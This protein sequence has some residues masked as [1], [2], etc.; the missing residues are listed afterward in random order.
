MNLTEAD[1]QILP[2]ALRKN[3]GFPIACKWYFKDW[4]PLWYQYL[5]H[6][7]MIRNTCVVAGIASGKSTGVA[8]SY[9]LD[10]LT[11]PY[12][13]A[14]NTS[15]TAKQAEIPF[16]MV[17]AW[18]DENPRLTP[19]IEDIS[20][21]PYPTIKFMNGSEWIFRTAGKDARFI[22][23]LEY[24][25][26][27][28]DECGLDF[29]GETVRVLRGRLRGVRPD[30]T[31]RMARLDTITSP[32]DAPWLRERFERGDKDNPAADLK[33][34]FSL[35]IS[36]YMNERLDPEQIALMESEYT[37]DMIDVELKGLF[38][39]Y[40]ASFFPKK[41]VQACTDQSLNDAAEEALHPEDGQVKRGYTVTEHPRYGITHF[42]L[43]SDP[44]SVYVM[45][46]DPG[47]DSYP[48][49]NAGVVMVADIQKKPGKIV[50]F[51]W[52]DGRGSYSPF[53]QSYKYAMQKYPC[54]LKGMDTTGTQKAIDELAF[55]NMGL[56][57]DG[58]NFQ[59]DKAPALNSLSLAVTNHDLVWPAVKG[60]VKQMSSYSQEHEEKIPQ[61][62]V[63][64]LA[65]IAFLA[66]FQP[67]QETENSPPSPHLQPIH[68]RAL[69]TTRRGRRK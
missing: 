69:R 54:F 65:Q 19:H 25:R 43:P 30:K 46:G 17:S 33:R 66:R 15:V 2:L 14:L 23:G 35:R 13:R 60:I 3:K 61:D 37:D 44:R 11:I 53:L 18:I 57:I 20:L 31:Q 58:I 29:S 52:I 48:K 27:N 6:Q 47:T 39:E 22:R 42:E 64:T 45:A 34:Y 68:Q 26:I 1:R 12:F 21:R 24:D 4:D 10:C 16:E 28:Y 38:P 51:D 7:V 59:R 5:F 55:E 8:A 62:I 49:R 50:Y 32:T 56:Q 36:T 67:H 40:G 9:M 41:H 63:M